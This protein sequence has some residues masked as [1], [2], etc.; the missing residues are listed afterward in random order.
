MK[1]I[2]FSIESSSPS[3]DLEND[4]FED[5]SDDNCLQTDRMKSE[6]DDVSKVKD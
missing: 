1:G 2:H 5:I 3:D 6:L 4:A